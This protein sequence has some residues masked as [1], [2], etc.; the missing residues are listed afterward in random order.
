MNIDVIIKVAKAINLGHLIRM[1]ASL[2][3]VVLIVSGCGGS[4]TIASTN[5]QTTPGG[6]TGFSNSG[7]TLSDTGVAITT[8]SAVVMADY[9]EQ[10]LFCHGQSGSIPQ[11]YPPTWDGKA[12]GSLHNIGVY[13][14]TPGS[15]ADHTGYTNDTNCTQAGCHAAPKA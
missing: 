2:M 1:T 11:P 3:A 5:Q 4:K 7:T 12:A 13:T 10:C 15:K 9:K 14:I 6:T 8:H